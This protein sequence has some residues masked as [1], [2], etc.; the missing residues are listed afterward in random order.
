MYFESSSFETKE[1]EIKQKQWE[2]LSRT[3]AR[4]GSP[5]GRHRE[6]S[7]CV[8]SRHAPP[9]SASCAATSKRKQS[10]KQA[11]ALW[12]CTPLV[13]ANTVPVMHWSKAGQNGLDRN[14][15]FS[16]IFVRAVYYRQLKALNL[17]TSS[18]LNEHYVVHFPMADHYNKKYPATSR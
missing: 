16:L 12:L 5:A 17:I 14:R 8:C 2:E 18:H 13:C 3:S 11:R 9:C 15:F 4:L 10:H 7:Y 1:P 6:I